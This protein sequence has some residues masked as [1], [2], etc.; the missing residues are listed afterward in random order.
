[1]RY[2]CGTPAVLVR[3][4]ASTTVRRAPTW[5]SRPREGL[6]G[7]GTCRGCPAG[8]PCVD[9]SSTLESPVPRAV[10]LLPSRSVLPTPASH[11]ITHPERLAALRRT[12]LLDTPAD[13][14]FDRLTRLATVV[15]RAPVGMLA[16]V[17]SDRDF[18]KSG[19]GLPAPL[20]AGR[21]LRLTPTLCHRV[22]ET[23]EPLVLEDVRAHP[24]FGSFPG[25]RMGLGAYLGVPLVTSD[26]YAIGTFC[27]ADVAPRRWSDADVAVLRDLAGAVTTEVEL[28]TRAAEHE[29]AERLL[30]ES[31]QQF[32]QGFHETSV[33]TAIVA[34]DGRLLD[35][36]DALC[37]LLGYEPGELIGVTLRRLTHP[38]DVDASEAVR[39]GLLAGTAS[40]RQIEK[41]YLHR[42]GHNVWALASVTLVRD[43]VGRPAHFV[44]QMQDITDRREAE[45]ALRERS[46]ERRVGKECRSR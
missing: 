6:C 35:V 15:L 45:R 38:D 1:M 43:A 23:G 3:Y 44:V 39:R 25:T 18:V 24:E 28:R 30:R 37:A 22:V 20:V 34:P 2:S 5:A 26:G 46:E 36:N 33:G 11:A 19:V 31:T 32:A 4:S 21:E 40:G 41:R 10:S 42:D 14:A 7:Q 13:E 17:D 12:A 8:V 29:R 27:V 9:L 16:L